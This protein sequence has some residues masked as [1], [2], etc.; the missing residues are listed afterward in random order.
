MRRV[1]M[2]LAMTFTALTGVY[3]MQYGELV[4][5]YRVTL[6]DKTYEVPVEYYVWKNGNGHFV[7]VSLGVHP[8]EYQAHKCM[9][10][11]V[12]WFV[13]NSGEFEGTLVVSWIKIPAE[14][15]QSGSEEE[16]Y[17]VSRD[18]GQLT[19]YNHVLPYVLHPKELGSKV[20]VPITRKPELF[21]D[22]H[23]HRPSWGVSEFILIPAARSTG[24]TTLSP[25]NGRFRS[26]RY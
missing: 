3:S 8:L 1:V 17:R 4:E 19:F 15:Y 7:W 24:T 13:Y 6:G 5:T 25:S 11:A 20:G 18:L 26:A 9:F 23:A 2:A 14:Y 12:K 22:V 10:E 16:K 21:L